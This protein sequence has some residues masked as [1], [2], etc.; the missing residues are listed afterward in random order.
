MIKHYICTVTGQLITDE[1]SAATL[2]VPV[3]LK[4]GWI[5]SNF[6]SMSAR[7]DLFH[8]SCFDQNPLPYM[9]SLYVGQWIEISILGQL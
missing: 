3:S 8:L 6:Y 7:N 9:K 1:D 2:L 4:D 5:T